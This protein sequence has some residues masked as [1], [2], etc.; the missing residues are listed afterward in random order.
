MLWSLPLSN[1]RFLSTCSIFRLCL[2][3][4]LLWS[5]RRYQVLS[6]FMLHSGI[7]VV[8]LNPR[9]EE[10]RNRGDRN[11]SIEIIQRGFC[12]SNLQL[13]SPLFLK[14]RVSFKSKEAK[15]QKLLSLLAKL[16][17]LSCYMFLASNSVFNLFSQFHL[18][19]HGESFHL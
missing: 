4:P 10:T 7:I 16:S 18:S 14:H 6:A 15:V 2:L 13:S 8:Y 5:Q 19:I 1:A 12:Y 17:F 9:E 11:R 3:P